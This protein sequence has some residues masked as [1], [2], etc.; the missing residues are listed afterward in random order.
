M[1]ELKIMSNEWFDIMYTESNNIY[2]MTNN[3]KGKFELNGNRL[4]IHWDVWGTEIFEKKEDHDVYYKEDINI[5][6]I[7]L[8]SKL[9]NEEALL[10]IDNKNVNL[11]Y[12][13]YCGS[14]KFIH[15]QLYITWDHNNT[16]EIF[17]MYNYGKNFSSLVKS[18]TKIL[19][20]KL[21]KNIAI[22]FPQFHETE[23]NNKFWGKGFT[24]WSL[25]SKMPEKV[26]DEVI[27]QPHHDIG[28]Y[29]L[30][31]KEHR[32][33]MENLS[34][35]YNIHGFCFY[36]YWFKNKKVMYEPTELMLIDGKPDKPFMFCWANE[37]WT[38]RWDGGNN[39]VLIE[40]DYSDEQGNYD[41][42]D[43]LLKFFKHKNYIKIN[44]KPV[45]I[46]YR[47]EAKD[48]HHIEKIIK[49]WNE[50]AIKNKFSGIYFMRFLGPFDNELVIDGI[51]GYVNFE[52]GYVSQ[53]HGSSI[54]SYD[55]NNVIFDQDKY[56]ESDYLNKNPDI[57]KCVDK[58]LLLNG[59]QH[60]RNLNTKEKHIRTSKFNIHDG[61]IALN[62]IGDQEIQYDN[63]NLGIFVGWNNS[64]RRNYTNKEYHKYPMIYNKITDTE[65]GETYS[66]ILQK[67]SLNNNNNTDFLFI[68]SWNE[69][70][71]QS[72]L[73]PNHI[74]GYNY[75]TQ[76]KDVY[77]YYYEL[78]TTKNILLFSHRG[79]GTEKYIHDLQ[80]IFKHYN[81]TYFGDYNK[82]I[83]YNE[84][85]NNIDMIHINSFYN[86]KNGFDYVHF[87][88]SYF[89]NKRKVMTIHDY[90]WLYPNDPNILCYK[91]KKQFLNEK[92]VNNLFLLFKIVDIIIFPSFNIF[93]NYNQL[94]SLDAFKDKIKIIPHMD[95]MIIDTNIYIP[96]IQDTIHISFMGNFTEYKGSKIF[97]QLFNNLKYYQGFSLKYHIFGYI[98][99]EEKREKIDHDHII[100]HYDY[101]DHT[102]IDTLYKENIH[103]I[104]HLSIFEESYCYA[105]TNSINSGIPILYIEHGAISERLNKS[106]KYFPTN[107]DNLFDNFQNSLN[108]II[109]NQDKTFFKHGSEY[110]YKMQPSKWNIENY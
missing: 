76:I 74:D 70:N 61:Q 19:D 72:S 40:Q 37:Q 2:R 94:V 33:Y 39:E 44:N 106:E 98:S 14:Y 32:S 11:K 109:N 62:K 21:I 20:K 53:N 41:H 101:D 97:K 38:K 77:H 69:W 81:I 110:K 3:D 58:K 103:L 56:N 24:E 51:E 49:Q 55:E 28:Y 52:P 5:F 57:K 91:M 9:F 75:L 63:Q 108:Y 1:N 79:G 36:H 27:K 16:E 30:T 7:I 100:Y 82:Q 6:K 12:S 67:S 96:P 35:F 31:H 48:K 85:Y 80:D 18:N 104:T 73:E 102:I 10:H 95:K 88:S 8:E 78:N 26:G 15:N 64:P 46:F 71:E 54:L 23:E 66:K 47:L 22:V 45:F 42:F 99:D 65:F 89:L 34:D 60:Y 105:L 17:Y 25:L 4:F 43:Y 83:N 29:N 84:L 93:N 50:L 59:Y 68:T 87:F 92:D 86:M 13:G 90:Q 107:I